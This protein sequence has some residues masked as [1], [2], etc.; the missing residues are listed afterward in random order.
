MQ[1]APADRRTEVNK[2]D[3]A[4]V[5]AAA[6]TNS[7]GRQWTGEEWVKLFAGIGLLVVISF[8]AVAPDRLYT[9]TARTA[10]FF[11]CGISLALLITS[12][13]ANRFQLQV[14]GLAIT[15]VGSSAVAVAVVWILHTLTQPEETIFALEVFDERSQRVSLADVNVTISPQQGAGELTFASRGHVLY[16]V[17]PST[18]AGAQIEVAYLGGPSYRGS[19]SR[20]AGGRA[21]IKQTSQRRLEQVSTL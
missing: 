14:R 19:I 10:L 11:L 18:V 20:P 12:D 6:K 1:E 21:F 7:E 4:D 17:F 15:L 2:K 3:A 9:P 13:V 8:V 5:G 16:V